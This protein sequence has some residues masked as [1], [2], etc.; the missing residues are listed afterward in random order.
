MVYHQFVSVTL[1]KNAA[2]GNFDDDRVV[3]RVEPARHPLLAGV[4][5]GP[6]LVLVNPLAIEPNGVQLGA[7]VEVYVLRRLGVEDRPTRGNR[8]PCRP[9][10]PVKRR[11]PGG[12][13]DPSTNARAAPSPAACTFSRCRPTS[14]PRP[15]SR[16]SGGSFAPT[17]RIFH[18]RITPGIGSSFSS[19]GRG[20]SLCPRASSTAPSPCSR[21]K[22]GEPGPARAPPCRPCGLP[23][24][25][26]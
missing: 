22:S 13:G 18:S 11:N 15:I 24:S 10:C 8:C 26:G 9:A 14:G 3:S 20:T 21:H 23:A 17:A 19:F 12:A 25:R 1:R 5:A 6:G 16:S 7:G 4:P 2:A